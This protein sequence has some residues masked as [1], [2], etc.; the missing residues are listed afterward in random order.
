MLFDGIIVIRIKWSQAT[1]QKWCQ[2]PRKENQ[3]GALDVEFVMNCN[4]LMAA[5]IVWQPIYK[6]RGRELIPKNSSNLPNC[7]FIH[8]CKTWVSPRCNTSWVRS[9][10]CSS[11][12]GQN[13]KMLKCNC[14]STNECH[15]DVVCEN[16]AFITSLVE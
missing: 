6:S 15:D 13:A 14:T 9:L 10:H 11:R 8:I 4:V 16:T 12:L 5:K 1:P 3:Y 2:Y 7:S